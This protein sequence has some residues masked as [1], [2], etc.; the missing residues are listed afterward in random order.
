VHLERIL[1]RQLPRSARQSPQRGIQHHQR[2]HDHH[3]SYI[4]DQVVSTIMQADLRRANAAAQSIIPTST[5]A[6]VALTFVTQNLSRK[7]LD[8][9]SLRGLLRDAR[10]ADIFGCR[11]ASEGDKGTWYTVILAFLPVR[12]SML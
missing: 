5:G 2:L 3:R 10:C 1:H 12:C 4:N 11:G 7:S 6:A 8:G 9:L